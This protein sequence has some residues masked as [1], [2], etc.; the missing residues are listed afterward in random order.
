MKQLFIIALLFGFVQNGKAQINKKMEKHTTDSTAIETILQELYIDGIYTGN[1]SKLQKVFHAGTL[2]FGDINGEPY[3]KTL[4]QYLY[5][6]QNRVNPK[7]SGKP[8]AGTILSIRVVNSIAFAE[9]KMK[10]YDFNYHDFLSLHKI[11]GRWLI[12]NKMFSNVQ[13]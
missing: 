6:V 8:F 12:V 13:P 4:E 7:D 2:L 1:L 9:V 3:A 11:D 5:G 10:M